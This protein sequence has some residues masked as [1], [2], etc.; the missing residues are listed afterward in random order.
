ML[1]NGNVLPREERR[2]GGAGFCVY[3]VFF[4]SFFFSFSFLGEFDSHSSLTWAEVMRGDGIPGA[5]GGGERHRQ[6]ETR[7]ERERCEE[8]FV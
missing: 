3:V 5:C 1:L 6:K 7:V 8:C 4:F 2:G